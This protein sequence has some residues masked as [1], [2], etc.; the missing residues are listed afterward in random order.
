M[1][2]TPSERCSRSVEK[3]AR[4]SPTP[5]SPPPWISWNSAGKISATSASSS[6]AD[7]ACAAVALKVC[8]SRFQPPTSID[9][10]S[11]SRM[12][13]MIEPTIDALTTSWSPSS[14]AKK[15]MISSGAL[16]NVT[17]SSPPMPGPAAGGQVLG[18]LA[19][20]RGRRDDAERRREEDED[21]DRR[22]RSRARP[23]SG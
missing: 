10:P 1:I 11:T 12:L 8:L 7:C 4:S 19:H 15:A 6:I 20:Q 22:A 17:F 9:A 16:P 5:G 3:S 2:A 14:S 13:P 21:R 18:R 23:R